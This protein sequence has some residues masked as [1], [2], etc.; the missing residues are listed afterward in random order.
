MSVGMIAAVYAALALFVLLLRR[1]RRWWLSEH[2]FSRWGPRTDVPCMTRRELLAEGVRWLLL[3]ALCLG[4]LVAAAWTADAF[5][6]AEWPPAMAATF[7]LFILAAM[8]FGAGAYLLL[9]GLFRSRRYVRPAECWQTHVA[10]APA[11]VP[12]RPPLAS[13]APAPSPESGRGRAG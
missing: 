5:G 10:G 6:R 12:L 3:G 11:T 1:N 9:R 13:P 2:L 4:V 8:G 7:L